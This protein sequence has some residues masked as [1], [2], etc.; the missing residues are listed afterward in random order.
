MSL[1]C[2]KT[3]PSSGGPIPKFGKAKELKGVQIFF[4]LGTQ[5][6]VAIWTL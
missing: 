5:P 2:L 6:E 4:G 3:Q 1:G